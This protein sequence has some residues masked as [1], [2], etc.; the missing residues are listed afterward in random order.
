MPS[1]AEVIR[2]LIETNWSLSGELSKTGT[3]A[4]QEVV[5]FFDRKQVQGNE[6]PKA[7]TVE[8]I[9]DQADENTTKHPHFTEVRDEYIISCHWRVG[10]VD[11]ATYSTA[12]LNVEDM[13]KEVQYLY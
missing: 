7:V 8:K 3:S 1:Q 13:A 10:D 2:D 9:N 11:P 5:R 12:L 4:M 6:W